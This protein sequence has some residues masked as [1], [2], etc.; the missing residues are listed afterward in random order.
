MTTELNP[1]DCYRLPWTLTD[2]ILHWLEPTKRC[3]L[4]CEGCYSRNEKGTDKSLAQIRD[5]ME[6]FVRNRRAD[7]VSITGGDPL[8]HPEIVEIVRIVKEEYGLKPVLNT[9]GMALTPELL[10]E[11]KRAGAFGFTFHVDSS[12]GRSGWE[13]KDETELN[14]L[15][16]Q[17]ARMVAEVGGLTTSFNSTVFPHTLEHVPAMVK[18][19]Q[20][21]IDIVH[22]MVFI[23]F[24]TTRTSEFEYYAQGERIDPK[25]LVYYDEDKL[26]RPLDA[27]EVVGAI[28]E[29]DPLYAPSAYLGGTRDPQSF[30][31]LLATRIATPD[32]VHGYVGRRFQEVTQLSH[33]LLFNRYMAY[34]DPRALRHGR[35]V[36]LGGALLDPDL[37]RAAAQWGRSLLTAPWKV[38]DRAH[39]QSLVIIQPIQPLGS[40]FTSAA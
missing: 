6:V 2:N 22:I 10:R 17:F 38:K 14:A 7:S 28:R 4:Y 5:D 37:R 8:I 23:L 21:H 19:A 34:S 32:T 16:L 40:I 36:M 39:V 11:L 18:W 33:H 29:A 3:N 25:E 20:E 9:N 24:R 30:K 26:P 12:Q 27:R 31:W 15:R 1:I 13:G 35:S